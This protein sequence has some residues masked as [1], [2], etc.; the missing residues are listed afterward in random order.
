MSED[1]S[2]APLDSVSLHVGRAIDGEEESIAW[3]YVRFSP[4]LEAQ[5]SYRLGT[6]RSRVDPHDVV[7]EAW[8]IMLP[9]LADL[10]PNAAGRSPVLLKFL[11]TTVVHVVNNAL[12]RHL[13]GEPQC[14]WSEGLD[15]ATS[16][17]IRAASSCARANEDT[18]EL[19]RVIE[20][21][22]EE[23]KEAVLLRGLEQLPNAAAAA[24]IGIEPNTLAQRYHRALEKIAEALPEEIRDHFEKN[25]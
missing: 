10:R 18:A 20:S 17:S 25:R 11:S 1:A 16:Q 23:A 19:R 3:L 13:R 15:A 12:R 4:W 14:P 21:L 5:A 6:L 2:P 24:R 9:R 8:G 7:Q 22:D